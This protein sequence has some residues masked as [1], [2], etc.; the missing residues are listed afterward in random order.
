MAIPDD[1][2]GVPNSGITIQ[3]DLPV[4]AENHYRLGEDGQDL[5]FFVLAPLAGTTFFAPAGTGILSSDVL[6]GD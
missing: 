4:V 1:A 2:W 5:S 6:L 3:S